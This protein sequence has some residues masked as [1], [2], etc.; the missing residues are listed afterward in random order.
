MTRRFIIVISTAA[1]LV[2]I[3]VLFVLAMFVARDKGP[4]DQ[5]VFPIVWTPATPEG[6]V[7]WLNSRIEIGEDGSGEVRD[8]LVGKMSKNEDGME[9]VEQSKEPYSG[10]VSW[11]ISGGRMHI[12]A[13]ASEALFFPMTG[14]G[15][16]VDWSS[17]RELLCDGSYADYAARTANR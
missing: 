2:I 1:F 14:P 16:G 9:C 8:L 13:G 11:D 6:N 10:A 17:M 5:L 4:G 15:D 7:P 3:A 12:D